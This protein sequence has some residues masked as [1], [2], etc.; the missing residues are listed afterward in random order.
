MHKEIFQIVEA[1]NRQIE[2]LQKRVNE[3]EE[4]VAAATTTH[5]NTTKIASKI[6]VNLPSHFDKS[7]GTQLHD[8]IQAMVKEILNVL[9]RKQLTCHLDR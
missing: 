5:L 9:G 4:K 2:E 1:H 3:L 6:L 7:E 8:L